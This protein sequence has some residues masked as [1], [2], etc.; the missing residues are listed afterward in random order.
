MNACFSLASVTKVTCI[1]LCPSSRARVLVANLSSS[2]RTAEA[3]ATHAC[4]P[5]LTFMPQLARS[6]ITVW[7]D[8]CLSNEL[9]NICHCFL[10]S[11]IISRCNSYCA[12]FTLPHSFWFVYFSYGYH[13]QPLWSLCFV[14]SL[15]SL[16]SCALEQ[17]AQRS[18][19]T[20]QTFSM[21][22]LVLVNLSS[23]VERLTLSMSLLKLLIKW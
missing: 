5:T 8:L 12:P 23:S 20:L 21:G 11:C 13:H 3:R 22:C 14:L 18:V 16:S 1:L 19:K 7:R 4:V 10:K 6:G 2:L 15:S 17:Q 9:L